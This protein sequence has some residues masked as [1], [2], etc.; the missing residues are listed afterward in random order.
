MPLIA[1]H[2]LS[3][4]SLHDPTQVHHRYTVGEIRPRRQVMTDVQNGDVVLVP[5]LEL[6][7]K[8]SH[9]ARRGKRVHSSG[10]VW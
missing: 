4:T 10:R 8:G 3:R 9:P 6:R 7:F 2:R 1:L 5:Q